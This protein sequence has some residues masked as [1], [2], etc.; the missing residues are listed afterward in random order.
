M[1]LALGVPLDYSIDG[2]N[3]TNSDGRRRLNNDL[4]A[5]DPYLLVITPPLLPHGSWDVHNLARDRPA[6]LT[7][8][9]LWSQQ[10]KVL[11]LVNKVVR[12]RV[13]ARR[14]IVLG[15]PGNSD[16][17][18][19]PEMKDVVAMLGRGELEPI[20]LSLVVTFFAREPA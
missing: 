10:E 19:Q 17:L 2:W 11:S 9:A 5:E 16:W 8:G 13:Q 7:S 15:D 1:G 20:V 4:R 6:A 14:H 3:C 18:N 12:D